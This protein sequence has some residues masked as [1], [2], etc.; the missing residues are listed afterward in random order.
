MEVFKRHTSILT[1]IH[2]KA[3]EQWLR[4]KL[5]EPIKF[6]DLQ[7]NLEMKRDAAWESLDADVKAEIRES[8][9]GIFSLDYFNNFVISINSHR[10]AKCLSTVGD[11]AIDYRQTPTQ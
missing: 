3:V 2:N 4:V 10:A 9:V 6:N 1:A 7:P 5:L 8:G 11:W